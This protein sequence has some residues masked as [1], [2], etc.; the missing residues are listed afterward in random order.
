MKKED[1]KKHRVDLLK[2]KKDLEEKLKKLTVPVDFGSDTESDFSEE[3]DEAEEFGAN[4]AV[5][6]VFKKELEG[7]N[8]ALEKMNSSSCNG[9][10][11]SCGG[12]CG[13]KK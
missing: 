3:A 7:I 1:I 9:N 10:C 11:D 2:K 4:L 12:C 8:E 6:Q 5:A 13:D